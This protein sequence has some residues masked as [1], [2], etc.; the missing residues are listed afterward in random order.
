MP[1]SNITSPQRQRQA[2]EWEGVEEK[3]MNFVHNTGNIELGT[4]TP[5]V[6]GWNSPNKFTGQSNKCLKISSSIFRTID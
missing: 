1:P 6:K 2:V 4:V 5:N 3:E